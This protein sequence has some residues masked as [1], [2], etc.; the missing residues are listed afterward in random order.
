MK[1]LMVAAAAALTATIGF[2]VESSNIVG[3]QT[4]DNTGKQ[5]VSLGA[6]FVTAGADCTFKLSDL[7]LNGGDATSDTLQVL[8]PVGATVSDTFVYV[9]AA[10]AVE[11]GDASFQGWYTPA[12]DT[13]GQRDV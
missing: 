9:S 8:E 2:S 5:F 7:V 4:T 10:Q 13:N 1:K 12:M 3:Y 6:T 11:W